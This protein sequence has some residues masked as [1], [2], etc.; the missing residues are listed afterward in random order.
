MM[1]IAQY[2]AA[3]WKCK[4]QGD[5]ARIAAAQAA[6]DAAIARAADNPPVFTR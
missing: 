6:L 5:P 4:K 1:T 3:L 2:R